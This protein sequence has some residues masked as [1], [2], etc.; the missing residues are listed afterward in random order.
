MS[1]TLYSVA[2]WNERYENNRSRILKE[3]RWV[4]VP[5]SHEG[6]AYNRIMARRDAAVIFAAWV[7]ILQI[8]SKCAPRGVLVKS[9]GEPHDFDSLAL[10]TR[11]PAKWFAKAVPFLVE[12][13]WLCSKSVAQQEMALGD[14]KVPE[15][16]GKVPLNWNGMEWNGSTLPAS[17]A[18]AEIYESYPR[19]VGRKAA[20]RAIALALKTKPA[21]ELLEAVKA[22]AAAVAR[23]PAADRQY[24][25]H[26]TTWFNQGR[27]D[28][29]RKTWERRH[30]DHGRT[31]ARTYKQADDY[32][33][34]P[35][36]GSV[37][38]GP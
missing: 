38:T 16:A 33:K 29:D 13:G 6:E 30:E 18:V 37:A 2:N 9:N 31:N 26:P 21:A 11:A 15:S 28:D 34:L 7:L 22:Y 3:L 10:K 24:V 14:Q 25:P 36:A 1:L 20:C 17:P 23:W 5:N 4:C 8:A 32:S 35:G 27:Y 12:I 19:K